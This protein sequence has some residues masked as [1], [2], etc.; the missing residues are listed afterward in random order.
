MIGF[1]FFHY[2][3]Y[4]W[5]SCISLLFATASLE[6][7]SAQDARQEASSRLV[8][9]DR[10]VPHWFASGA[11]FWYRNDLRDGKR[12]FV[13]VDTENGTQTFAFD[14]ESVALKM[15]VAVDPTRLPID[16]L[17]FS[18]DSSRTILIGEKRWEWISQTKELIETKET[19]A[20]TPGSESRANLNLSRPTHN[21]EETSI[22]FENKSTDF[23]EIFWISQDGVRTSYGKLDA[24]TTKEQHTFGGHQ[25]VIVN[26]RGEDLLLVK[27]TDKASIVVIDGTKFTPATPS[28]GRNRFRNRND[29]TANGRSPDGMWTAS[30]KDHNVLLKSESD[31]LESALSTDGVDGNA[32]DHLEWSPDAKSLIAFRVEPGEKKEVH[33]IQS[34]PE[35]GGRAKL[36]SRP[37]ALPGDKFATYE[38]NLFDI[39]AGTQIRPSVDRFESEW[40]RPR[41][42]WSQDGAYFT[43]HQVDRGHQRFRLI[44]VDVSN[45]TVRNIID[46]KSSTF[47]WTA[48]TENQNLPTVTWLEKSNGDLLYVSERSG[49]R[50]VYLID[51]KL[52][53][54]R[55]AVTSGDWVVRGIDEIDEVNRQLWFRASG[56][57][58]GQDPYL[59]HYGRVNF[60][61]TGLVWLTE[62]N[63][64]HTLQFSPDKKFA[65]DSYSRVDLAPVTELRRVADGKLVCELQRSDV[66][67][68]RSAGWSHPE[69]FVAKAR[70]GVT[71]IWG[72][73]C[74]PNNIDPKRSY[75]VIEDI[76]SGPHG[77]HVPKSFS[78]IQRYK[79]LTDLGFIVVK[80]DGMGTA[81][82]SK[83]FHDVCW[84]NLKD[85]GFEDRI[86]WMKGAATKHPQMD[87]TRVGIYGTSAGGQNAA[88]AVLFHPEF[89]KVAV[90]AC[91]C[92]DNRMDKASWNEQWMGYPTGTHYSDSSNIDNA[93][94]LQGKLL[95]I[96]GE[97]D[98]NVP[99][100]STMRFAD[101]LIKANKDFDLLVVPNA[102]HGMGGA[103]GQRKMHDFFVRNFL[104]KT[105]TN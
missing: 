38:L 4:A 66:D 54:V 28:Q 94:L 17:E 90:A 50:H 84:H 14:H 25:W 48:H 27:A 70:D 23:V 33:V 29:S 15:G 46:E 57:F 43:Y 1:N 42:R 52:G 55:N 104:G 11:K 59:I 69:V 2:F 58:P 95:L 91:G 98:T 32:Y 74:L 60:D 63:G 97:M 26:K 41:L 78:P 45:G 101:K 62:S 16:G 77:S 31:Q 87:L 65:I 40:E 92:H 24:G 80:I 12:E 93:H 100:E 18:D 51:G 88:G 81:N 75:P 7:T 39:Q 36:H 56:C 71:D 30:I 68:L 99:P 10:I 76:Y 102:G 20:P 96:V 61:G 6:N 72:F 64:N 3:K 82:R 49:W 67:D 103:Y 35:G 8:F 85:A 44:E 89:Y 53:S 5:L 79:S 105:A 73:V 34:S 9:R 83:A 37:Y 86:L 47:V 13:M 22:S 19:F 21:G